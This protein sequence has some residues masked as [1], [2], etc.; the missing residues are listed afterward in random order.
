MENNELIKLKNRG[1]I[2]IRALLSRLKKGID[3]KIRLSL[4]NFNLDYSNIN[5]DTSANYDKISVGKYIDEL[6]KI[7]YITTSKGNYRL[8]PYQIGTLCGMGIPPH[9]LDPE[10]KKDFCETMINI[11][12]QNNLFQ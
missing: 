3:E 5:H 9:C 10:T 4:E 8:R 1:E 2:K 11:C 6:L 7:G 12:N